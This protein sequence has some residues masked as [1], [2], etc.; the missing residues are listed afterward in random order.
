VSLAVRDAPIKTGKVLGMKGPYEEGLADYLGSESCAGV[1]NGVG[2]ALTGGCA[3]WVLSL[4]IQAQLP[5][6]DVV[7][8]HGRQHWTR[9]FGE[10]CPD[11]AGSETLGMHRRT[12]HGNRES[13]CLPALG[14]GRRGKSKDG[15]QG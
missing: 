2:E 14:A 6:A 8:T 1:G 10:A 12:L 3:G 15:S 5:G 4:E 11:L 13:L 7:L 9:R